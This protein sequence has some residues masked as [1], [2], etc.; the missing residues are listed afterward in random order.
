MG[1][2]R[3]FLHSVIATERKSFYEPQ[4]DRKIYTNFIEIEPNFI[5]TRYFL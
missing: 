3:F 5:E 1:E 2:K 4:L